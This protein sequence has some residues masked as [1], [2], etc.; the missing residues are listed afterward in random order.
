MQ[1]KTVAFASGKNSRY[2]NLIST[3]GRVSSGV[4][5]KPTLS[6]VTEEDGF[7]VVA[8]TEVDAIAARSV[9]TV[10]ENFT[11][12][13]RFISD[14]TSLDGK[15]KVELEALRVHLHRELTAHDGGDGQEQLETM[16]MKVGMCVS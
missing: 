2:P 7:V 14:A 1:I 12:D 5:Q 13:S 11:C 6:E 8:A 9:S 10:T 15:S 4:S 16:H 3:T